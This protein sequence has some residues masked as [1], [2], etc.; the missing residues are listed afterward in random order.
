MNN[1]IENSTMDIREMDVLRFFFELNQQQM[2][3]IK[4]QQILLQH[5]VQNQLRQNPQLHQ[6]PS[7]FSPIFKPKESN[8]STPAGPTRVTNIS[9]IPEPKIVFQYV[10][11]PRFPT[12][13]S[14]PEPKSSSED[15]IED[16]HMAQRKSKNFQFKDR[17]HFINLKEQQNRKL[18]MT[19]TSSVHESDHSDHEV[20]ESNLPKLALSSKSSSWR[21]SS[22]YNN[23][24]DIVMSEYDKVLRESHNIKREV[25]DKLNHA[26]PVSYEYN[27]NKSRIRTNYSDPQIADDRTR[28][29]IASRRSRQ[30]KKFL[31]HIQ[32]YCVDFDHDENFLL[33]KQERW[34]CAMIGNLENKLLSKTPERDE[35][36]Y[37]IRRQCGFE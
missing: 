16:Y 33:K 27:K 13:T 1:S 4:L 6:Q 9:Q 19:P 34:L 17:C 26:F 35:E 25:I 30:R 32:Q 7:A 37:K 2:D 3:P 5:Q 31:T 10:P 21:G 18:L 23:L 24:P 22:I 11:S 20:I 14:T 15:E 12:P 28:N 36:L 8:I 29:N